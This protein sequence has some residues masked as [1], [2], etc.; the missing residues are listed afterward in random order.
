M[1]QESAVRTGAVC[2]SPHVPTSVHGA[3]LICGNTSSVCRGSAIQVGTH[4]IH[5]GCVNT[6]EPRVLS[7]PTRLLWWFVVITAAKS[8]WICCGNF[9]K[10]WLELWWYCGKRKLLPINAIVGNPWICIQFVK[11]QHSKILEDFYSFLYGC[12][13]TRGATWHR[14][15]CDLKR[16]HE[17]PKPRLIMIQFHCTQG[18]LLFSN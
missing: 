13:R 12:L 4:S 9:Q 8:D 1:S 17:I 7:S 6:A 15:R 3:A 5:T 18:L 10:L 11:T 14:K 2:M 16:I